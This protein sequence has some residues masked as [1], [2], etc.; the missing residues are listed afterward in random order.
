MQASTIVRPW[1]DVITSALAVGLCALF[2]GCDRAPEADATDKQ[3]LLEVGMVHVPAGPFIMGSNKTD[4]EGVQK[5]FGFV[6]PLYVDEHPE[7][8]VYVEAFHIDRL[9]VSNADYKEFVIQTR[10]TEPPPW[11]Q[12]G[13]NVRWD[14]LEKADLERLRWIA[15]EYFKLDRDTSTLDKPTLLNELARIQKARDPLPVSGVSWYDAYSYCKW[16]GK[17]LPTEAEWEKAARGVNG[18]EYPWGPEWDATKTNTG[19][20]VD[21][22]GDVMRTPGETSG[23]V[24]P[25]GASDMAGNVSEWVADWYEAY[26]GSQYQSEYYGG[27]HKVVR[28]GGAGEGHY[29]I[30]AFFRAARRSHADPSAMTTDV[31]FRCAKEVNYQR[32]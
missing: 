19:E 4:G 12:N 25:F 22:A 13:Y 14:V 32:D 15:T 6:K 30:S 1:F 10:Y 26:P 23:D 21:D 5:E 29:A 27:V 24:S 20:Q 17:R 18:W 9:E 7:R 3:V 31:G 28:G 8:T 2:A 11:V 16:A